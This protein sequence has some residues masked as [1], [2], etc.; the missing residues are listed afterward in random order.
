MGGLRTFRLWLLSAVAVVLS[1]GIAV[2]ASP[3]A[4][5]G[6]KTEST[7]TPETTDPSTPMMLAST[8]LDITVPIIIGLSVLVLGTVMVGWAFLATGRRNQ[9]R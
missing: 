9:H 3:A 7:L 6:L 4:F 8:G 5:A 1:L 2:L